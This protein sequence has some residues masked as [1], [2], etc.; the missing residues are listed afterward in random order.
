MTRHSD[1]H[2][3]RSEVCQAN[4]DLA[5]S[6]LVIHTFGNV[7]GFHRDS[8]IMIIKPSGVPYAELTPENLVAVD[9]AGA[10]LASGALR[11]SSDTMT[12]IKLYREFPGIGAVAHTHSRFATAWAQARKPLPCMGTTHAD[13]FYGTIPC[14]ESLSIEQIAGDYEEETG[15][16]IVKAFA[17]IFDPNTCP[18]V[19]VACHGPFTWAENPSQAVFHSIMLESIA[20]IGLYTAGLGSENLSIDQTL[21]DKHYQRKHGKSATYGQ[22]EH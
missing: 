6:G 16:Q 9:L 17:G 3:L 8:G 18:G 21:L 10:P 13:Y 2:R 22:G 12:H 19:L 5:A 7:S 14:T 20:E 11:P 15:V 1:L 4:K